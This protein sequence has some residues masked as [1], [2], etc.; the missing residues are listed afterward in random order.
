MSKSNAKSFNSEQHAMLKLHKNAGGMNLHAP[1]GRSGAHEV[2]KSPRSFDVLEI[3]NHNEIVDEDSALPEGMCCENGL[4]SA[5]TNQP[6][7]FS[8]YV[9]YLCFKSYLASSLGFCSR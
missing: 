9:S 5:V 4:R 3:K 1:S 2:N 7:S 8:L 6:K